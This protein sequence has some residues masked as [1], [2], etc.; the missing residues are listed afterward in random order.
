[1]TSGRA[2]P[3]GS[4]AVLRRIAAAPPPRPADTEVCELCGEAVPE[5]HRHVV[6]LQ[7][8]SL[9]CTCRP[10]WLLF[11]EGSRQR[12]RGVPERHLSF[13]GFSL[14]A[15]QWDALEIPVGLVFVFTSSPLGRRVALYPGPA[16]ATESE[17]PLAAWDDVLAGNP[18]LAAARDDVEALFL[19]CLD[20][21][22]R[23]GPVR[24]WLVPV[25]RCYELVGRLR[26]VWRGFDGGT[27]ARA[28]LADFTA[29]V[30]A[31][32]RPAP[33]AGGER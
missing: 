33:P 29:D 25:D 31:R 27:E 9:L 1:M 19:T 17:L 15:P 32:S 16:G 7:A 2:A 8:H 18:Q 10:C 14:P 13:P 3:P 4:L 22:S 28:A 26:R 12:Y 5:E 11:P 6:D 30:A 24:C 21:G 23:T 20:V